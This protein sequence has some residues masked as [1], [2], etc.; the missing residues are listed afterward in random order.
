MW[1]DKVAIFTAQHRLLNKGN[2]LHYLALHSS[3]P[4]HHPYIIGGSL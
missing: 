4:N 3:K 2:D 1:F